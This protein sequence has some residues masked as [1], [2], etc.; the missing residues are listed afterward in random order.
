MPNGI[1]FNTGFKDGTQADTDLGSCL[2]E[3]DYLISVYPQLIDNIKASSLFSWGCNSLGTLGDNSSINKSSPVQTVSSGTNWKQVSGGDEHTA[4][5][6]TDGT[7]WLWGDGCAGRLGDNSAINKSS[8]VQTVSSGTNWKQ[9]DA[10][11]LHTAAIKTDG[12]LWLWGCNYLGILGD[13]STIN[14]SSPVQTVSSGNNWKQVDAGGTHTAAIKTDGTLWLWGQGSF[15]GRLGDNS[16][17]NKSSP[18]QTVS[19]GTNWKQ[20][21]AG[22]AHTAAIKT[23]GTLWLW[24]WE[25]EGR[26]GD[27]STASR[28]SPVQ[29]VSSGANWKQ[30]SAGGNKTA[31]IKTDGT[32]W[33]WGH[34]VSGQLGNNSTASRSSPVQTVSSGANWKQVDSTCGHTAA[35]KTDGTLWSW[36]S[37]C[38]GQLGNNSTPNRSSP[39]QTVSS[40][41]NWKQVIAGLSHTAAIR[42]EGDF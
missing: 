16:T 38:R 12:T 17:I 29:T 26:L 13:N 36:G 8:P 34:G 1:S 23:D 32:L 39:V 25:D 42:E 2:I 33:L 6:K 21:S 9:V 4:A 7:L 40:G 31:A 5:I 27:N 10:G 35:I 30:V 11:C 37:A 20:V 24:G 18:V 15:V 41:T 28:S 3:K 14:R 22:S 19:S